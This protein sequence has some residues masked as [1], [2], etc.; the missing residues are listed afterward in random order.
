MQTATIT[1][2]PTENAVALKIGGSGKSVEGLQ[3][4]ARGA[5]AATRRTASQDSR[6]RRG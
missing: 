4:P 5:E 6:G 2:Y 1:K 3:G